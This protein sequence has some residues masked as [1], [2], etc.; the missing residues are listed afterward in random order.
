MNTEQT[1]TEKTTSAETDV[2]RVGPRARTTRSSLARRLPGWL[3]EARDLAERHHLD[4]IT[5]A[6]DSLAAQ[7][8]RP[9][10]RV[11]VVGEFNRGKSTLVNTLIGRKLLPTGQSPGAQ[12]DIAVRG[13]DHAEALRLT[14]PDKS[15]QVAELDERAVW[16]ELLV[17][18][19]DGDSVPSSVVADV[20]GTWLTDMDLELVDTPGANS[21]DEPD[22][23]RLRRSVAG[24]DGALFVISAI[25]PLG[26]TERLLLEEELLCRHLPNIAVVVTMLDRVDADDRDSIV[27]DLRERLA[28]L[29]GRGALPI[30]T[31]PHPEEDDDRATALRSLVGGWATQADRGRWR[32]RRI[33]ATVADHCDT[34]ARLATEA[35][36]LARLSEAEQREHAARAEADLAEEEQVWS[37]LRIGVQSRQLDTA[38]RVQDLLDGERTSVMAS[39]QNELEAARDPHAW[40]QRELPTRLRWHLSVMAKA[41]ERAMLARLSQDTDWLDAA[42]RRGL[43]EAHPSPVPRALGLESAPGQPTAA[44]DDLSKLRLAARV[45]AQGGAALGYLVAAARHARLP[46]I[47]TIGFSVLSSL[48]AERAI[49]SATES[50]RRQ[51]D[52]LLVRTVDESISAFGATAV[53]T[54]EELYGDV[55][56]HLH[57]SH[58]MWQRSYADVLTAVDPVDAT[59]WVAFAFATQALATRVRA[60]LDRTATDLSERGN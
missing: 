59:D 49:R 22:V 31:A 53:T 43:P 13:V 60:D 38:R 32:D 5:E 34:M 50:Q 54:V 37:E 7:R 28:A 41:V 29:P 18:D 24:A 19:S 20:A 9:A 26:I 16:R 12:V 57:G 40:W 56:G 10:F 45:G 48:I 30:L 58:E 52:A 2:G 6:L 27:D 21:G 3:R 39:L 36:A 4:T 25:S 11:A 17:D 51:I 23:E 44:V 14:W 1:N 47:Y 55:V 35:A 46:M 8:G 42:V 33:A 15:S